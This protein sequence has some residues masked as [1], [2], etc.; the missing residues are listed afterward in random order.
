MPSYSKVLLDAISREKDG[1]DYCCPEGDKELLRKLLCEINNRMNTNL[2][3]LAELDAFDVYEA[4]DIIAQYITQFS[5][6]SVRG[7]LVP[8]L[9]ADKVVDCDKF[10]LQLYM[11]FK[12]SDEYIAKPGEPSPAHIYVRYDNA[13]KNLKPKRLANEMLALAYNPRDAFYLPFT[14]RMLAS[15]KIPEL[16]DLLISFLSDDCITAQ[17]V[18]IYESEKPF[19]P[20]VE[21]I[22]RDLIFTAIDGLRYYPSAETSGI[23]STFASSADKD[24]RLASKRVI[25]A[26]KKSYSRQ[27]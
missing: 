23:I 19:Y 24:I 22:K 12:S 27:E 21:T 17:D 9:T 5:S 25:K 1:I 11:H 3:Y 15:W 7:Y 16:K 2:H 10:I 26:L 20:S 4:S 14:M 13:I 8:K 6:E 18:G